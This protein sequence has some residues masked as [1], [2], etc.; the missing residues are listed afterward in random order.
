MDDA[1]TGTLVTTHR[2][3]ENPLSR[4]KTKSKKLKKSTSLSYLTTKMLARGS[5]GVKPTAPNLEAFRIRTRFAPA[6]RAVLAGWPHSKTR[7]RETALSCL[8]DMIQPRRPT[9]RGNRRR[10]IF[11]ETKPYG[12]ETLFYAADIFLATTTTVGKIVCMRAPSLFFLLAAT[13]V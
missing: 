8:V 12:C 3:P 6:R 9:F 5:S 7:N 2:V 4:R 1:K 13:P 10:L 11:S